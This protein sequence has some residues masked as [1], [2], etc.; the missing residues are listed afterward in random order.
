VLGTKAEFAKAFGRDPAPIPWIADVRSALVLELPRIAPLRT[1][2]N[3]YIADFSRAFVE[4]LLATD[5][6]LEPQ[7][8]QWETLPPTFDTAAAAFEKFAHTQDYP[9]SLLWVKS[10]DVVLC[11]WRGM[12]TNHVWKGDSRERYDRVRAEYQ[13]AMARNVGV[14][15]E[16][17][18]KTGMWAI[19]RLYVPADNDDAE[20][21]M[22]PKMGVKHSV[23]SDPLPVVL[24]ESRFLWWLVKWLARNA[25]SAWD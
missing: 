5:R 9:P 14:A 19:C 12:L 13:S 4:E 6:S 16:A 21:R 17:K 24:I 10:V 25:P 11:R 3:P 2:A 15:F 18:G 23:A 20:R 1:H 7:F 8:P 22:I